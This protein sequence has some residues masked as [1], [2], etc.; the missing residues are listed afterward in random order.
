MA[1]KLDIELNWITNL[2]N[3]ERNVLAMQGRIAKLTRAYNPK[4]SF[5]SPLD[6]LTEKNKA[7]EKYNDLFDSLFT[8]FEALNK[9]G[10]LTNLFYNMF[11]YKPKGNILSPQ[12]LTEFTSMSAWEEIESI[13]SRRAYQQQKKRALERQLAGE[14]KQ[15][16]KDKDSL[17]KEA[18]RTENNIA[19]DI[20]NLSSSFDDLSN[21]L[22]DI[23]EK[24]FGKRLDKFNKDAKEREA[25][26]KKQQRQQER[27]QKDLLNAFFMR[28][29]KLGVWGIVASQVMRYASKAIKYVYDTSMQGLDWERTIRGGSYSGSWF[30]KDVAAYQRAGIEGSSIQNFQRGLLG[31]LGKVKLGMGNAA[32]LM[33]LGV[34]ALGDPTR[35]EKQIEKRLRSIKDKS[36]SLALAQMMG[37]DYNM[38]D[39]IYSGRLDRTKSGYSDSAIKKWEDVA[40]KFNNLITDFRVFLFNKGGSFFYNLMNPGQTVAQSNWF[41]RLSYAAGLTNPL[42]FG[43]TALLKFG[44][45]DVIVR[46][47][48]GEVM[49]T[50]QAGVENRDAFNQLNW[51][52]GGG[53]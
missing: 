52:Q 43:T 4:F 40:D 49:G 50:G 31:Y 37:L 9:K 32:P 15:K 35:V 51:T 18:T 44:T 2:Q 46:N 53:K 10:G 12:E 19:K 33:Y 39:A 23:K 7:L 42:M 5:L 17:L 20:E 28:W 13:Y 36:V 22:S 45:V 1:V 34:D 27:N 41:E 24:N 21:I 38:W 47:E 3:I 14:G 30:G 29:G 6:K 25:N 8:K 48:K 11:G 16:I 26:Q